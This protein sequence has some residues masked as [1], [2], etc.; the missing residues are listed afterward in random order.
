MSIEIGK[1][2]YNVVF[3]WIIVG[4]L[5]MN[6]RWSFCEYLMVFYGF[7]VVFLWKFYGRSVDF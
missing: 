7:V 5:F 2:H 1:E 4:Q 3:L 6:M